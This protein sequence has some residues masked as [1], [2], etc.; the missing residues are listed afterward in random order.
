[1][2]IAVGKQTQPAMSRGGQLSLDKV[3]FTDKF[4]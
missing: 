3:V 2:L 1:M 4:S